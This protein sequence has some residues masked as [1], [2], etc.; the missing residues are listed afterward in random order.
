MAK[1]NPNPSPETRFQP[2]VATNPGGKTSEQRQREI[3]NAE[4]ATRIRERLL[5]ALEKQIAAL[6]DNASADRITT[7]VLKMLKDS[8][9][10]GLGAPKQ[11]MDVTNRLTVIL[12]DDATKL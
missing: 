1:G 3:A 8:E 9:D 5:K 7:E 2:G 12:P 6:D 10:R 11:E 4:R